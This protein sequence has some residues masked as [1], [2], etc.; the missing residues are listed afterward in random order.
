MRLSDRSADGITFMHAVHGSDY[1]LMAFP[2]SDTPRLHY[3]SWDVPSLE[4]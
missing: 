3:L 1:H 2:K 4:I